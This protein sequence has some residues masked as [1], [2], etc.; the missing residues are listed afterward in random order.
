[1]NK[2]DVCE[3]PIL[4]DVEELNRR[5][6]Y[7]KSKNL[8]LD[9][10][11]GKPSP[12][13]LDLACDMLTAVNDNSH[14]TASSGFD[15]RNYG[16]PFGLPELK[17]LFAPILGV[18]DEN[19]IVCG[20]SSLNIMYDTIARA[21]IFGVPGGSEPWS[22]QGKIKFLCP[23]PGYDRHF[24]ICE[25]F[26]IEMIA[27]KMTDNGPDMDEIEKIVSSDASVKGIW[28]VPKYSNPTGITYSDETVKRMA[29]MKPAA[30][31]FRIFWDNAYVIHDLYDE[32]DKL[33]NILDECKEAGNENMVYMF[34]STSKITYSGAGV[35][36]IASSD[37]NI[38]AIKKQLSVQT[39]GHDKLNQLRHLRFFG[40]TEKIYDHMKKHAEILKPKFDI[41]IKKLSEEISDIANWSN[42]KG[43]YFI[44]VELARECAKRTVAL[45]K[46]AGVVLTSAGAPFPYGIDPNDSNIRIAPSYPSVEELE[47]AIDVFC[48]CAKIAYAEKYSQPLAL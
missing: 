7:I 46:E 9:M 48:L 16:C 11:R 22:K 36:F 24:S 30:K 47:K 1:M 39:I 27:V 3:S 14:C 23:C 34:A 15:C 33:I 42:P 28:C 17:K 12:E 21:L 43:G 18:S 2:C 10:S 35:A 6:E 25:A 20:N 45:C 38:A 19:I 32:S 31:D 13:Q 40:T 29:S 5:F 4:F 26:G 44:S 37:E 8:S 41:V